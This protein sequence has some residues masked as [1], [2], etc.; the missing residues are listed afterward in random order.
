MV[1][2]WQD[3]GGSTR[4]FETGAESPAQN[5]SAKTGQMA[6]GFTMI[7]L[8]DSNVGTYYFEPIGSDSIRGRMLK[9]WQSISGGIYYFNPDKNVSPANSTVTKTGQMLSGKWYSIAEKPDGTPVSQMYLF[10]RTGKLTDEWAEEYSQTFADNSWQVISSASEAGVAPYIW[11]VG[12]E[13]DITLSSGERVTL[14]IYG[15]NVDTLTAGGKAG[16]TFG[17]KEQMQQARR[18]H[19][20]DDNTVGF[21]GTEMYSWLN[22]ELYNQ[23][24]ADLRG[25]IKTTDKKTCVGGGNGQIRCDS[26]KIFLFSEEECFGRAIQSSGGE[27]ASNESY[28]IFTDDVSRVKI[29]PGP[30]IIEWWL[31][32]PRYEGETQFCLVHSTGQAGYT[33]ASW[34]F[35]GVV[36]GF[37]V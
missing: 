25:V 14:Q 27:S 12:D 2:G 13:K 3:Q 28:P 24:P 16:M 21:T 22:T 7:R 4:Y 1:K 26:M 20:A 11:N 19:S 5:L 18:M 15:F 32:S 33:S 10:D 35:G 36:F 31:R 23:L 30:Q 9:G 37:C 8:S 17:L 34:E 6:I 29:L